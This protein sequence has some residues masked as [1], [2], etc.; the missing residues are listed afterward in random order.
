M[1]RV[2]LGT[3][4]YFDTG[5]RLSGAEPEENDEKR[6]YFINNMVK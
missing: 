5:K 3:F 1:N 4:S 2:A 6:T